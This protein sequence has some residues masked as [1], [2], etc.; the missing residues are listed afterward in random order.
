MSLDNRV[1][2]LQLPTG[3]P[4]RIMKTLDE[5]EARIPLV[6]GASESLRE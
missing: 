5:V 6:D 4:T 1:A 2:I 3:A